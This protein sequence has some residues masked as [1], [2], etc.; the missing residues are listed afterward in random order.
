MIVHILNRFILYQYGMLMSKYYT[1]LFFSER[2]EM[3][4]DDLD[5]SIP[6][7]NYRVIDGELCKIISGLGENEIKEYFKRVNDESI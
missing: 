5:T 7:G 3:K 6:C 4:Q 1:E 2:Q